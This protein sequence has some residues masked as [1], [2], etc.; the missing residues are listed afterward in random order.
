MNQQDKICLI[1]EL[2]EAGSSI[3]AIA[4]VVGNKPSTVN[5]LLSRSGLKRVRRMEDDIE[6]IVK[7]RKTG[8]TLREIS[9]KTGYTLTGLSMFLRKIG[10]G[11]NNN[12]AMEAIEPEL[13]DE[14]TVFAKE[15]QRF[16]RCEYYGKKYIDVTEAFM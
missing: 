10:L 5:Q 12:V 15:Y 6:K 13:I 8:C 4:E 3:E 2:Y 16:F 7:L 11:K 14:N 9:E 1:R